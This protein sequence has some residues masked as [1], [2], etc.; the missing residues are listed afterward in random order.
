MVTGFGS[1]EIRL[2]TDTTGSPHQSEGESAG[3][4]D[5][6]RSMSIQC[7][8]S[9]HGFMRVN[10]FR[11]FLSRAR[12]E[13][14]PVRWLLPGSIAGGPIIFGVTLASSRGKFCGTYEIIC[15]LLRV[16]SGS[17]SRSCSS[18]RAR[19]APR[20]VTATGRGSPACPADGAARLR[21]R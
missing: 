8:A 17:E 1:R 13:R 14:A 11:R 20:S 12:G 16:E 21:L 2:P 9:V 7:C 15:I 6:R 5:V 3:Q 4:F 10:P 19:S 18:R